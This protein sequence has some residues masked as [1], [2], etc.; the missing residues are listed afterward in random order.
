MAILAR[1]S[2]APSPPHYPQ[3][4][5]DFV[6]KADTDGDGQLSYV[7][8]VPQFEVLFPHGDSVRIREAFKKFKRF[9]T[10][11]DGDHF[12]SPRFLLLPRPQSHLTLLSPLP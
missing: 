12:P 1:V 7:E 2:D 5:A 6:K 3:L 8:F 11:R 10:D 4:V 9:D